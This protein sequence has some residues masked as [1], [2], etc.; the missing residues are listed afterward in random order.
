MGT[1]AALRVLAC[2]W[3]VAAFAGEATEEQLTASRAWSGRG[4]VAVRALVFPNCLFF[5]RLVLLCCFFTP[6]RGR[7]AS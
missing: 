7:S 1:W 6:S 5:L 2:V 4:G 3:V